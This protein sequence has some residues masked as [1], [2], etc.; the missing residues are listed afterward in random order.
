MNRHEVPADGPERFALIWAGLLVILACLIGGGTTS[1]LVSDRIIQSLSVPLGIYALVRAGRI[2][3]VSPAIMTIGW[4]ALI[5]LLV[6][7]N[8][9]F[10]LPA[11]NPATPR[12]G[13]ASPHFALSY[14]L[15]AF[16]VLFF[17]LYCLTLSA[18]ATR[19]LMIAFFC[20][21]L[22][23][24]TVAAIQ[25]SA[26]RMALAD[27]LFYPVSI[28]FFAN[29]NH[30]SALVYAMVPMM[31]W[32]LVYRMRQSLAFVAFGLF[33]MLLL[34]AAGSMAAMGLVAIM[35]IASAYLFQR[36]RYGRR[37]RLLRAATGVS[38]VAGIAALFLL[39]QEDA[40]SD[41]LRLQV[42]G[43]VLKALPGYFPL[44]S[45]LGGFHVIYPRFET[46]EQDLSV[47]ANYAHNDWL[48]LALETGLAGMLAM[49]FLVWLVASRSG[50]SPL[51]LAA[52]LGLGGLFL[53]SLVDYPMRTM[54]VAFL[55]AF[56]LAILLKDDRSNDDANRKP[57]G[58]NTRDRQKTSSHRQI[59]T[60]EVGQPKL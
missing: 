33:Q 30:F 16:S 52:G 7:A 29:G 45:G 25:L 47:F 27:G 35:L 24:L 19:R 57:A 11:G 42:A 14:A 22:I 50:A 1:Y 53:H 31:A 9:A 17:V 32:L 60:V 58:K 3:I 56:Y 12:W 18:W 5:V 48:E 51:K 55:A 20:G 54:A 4:L 6:L 23:N 44:G 39:R 26:S 28:G 8:L 43:N 13:A 38:L 10:L 41:P 59:T 40:F 34:F 15:F 46:L 49:A 36:D 37:S 2:R 21:M